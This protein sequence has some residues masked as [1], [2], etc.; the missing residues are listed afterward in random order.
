MSQNS[1]LPVVSFN[2]DKTVISEGGEAQLITFNLS[3]P[4]PNGGLAI[5]LRID[6]PDGEPGDTDNAL[7]LF[8]NIIDFGDGVENG[9]FVANIT[10]AEG[11]TEATIG[12]KARKE[13]KGEGEEK[14]ERS[15]MEKEKD[16]VDSASTTITTTIEEVVIPTVSF[17][18]ETVLSTEG[19]LL[20]RNF[21]L[22]RPVPEAGL[23]VNVAI[24]QN[25]EPQPGDTRFN[26][27][28]S[29]GYYFRRRWLQH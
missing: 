3:E 28:A 7:E 5:K 24:T 16:I 4:A 14:E 18:S 22:D 8:S 21:S 1:N 15:G 6:D 13:E 25:T 29:S 11:A 23:T 19:D 10:I 2:A 27:E 20:A 26:F 17:F 9:V 12:I